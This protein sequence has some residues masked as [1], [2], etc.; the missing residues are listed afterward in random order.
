MKKRFL[1][2]LVAVTM[3]ISTTT[4][5]NIGI[6]PVTTTLTEIPLDEPINGGL[7]YHV[8]EFEVIVGVWFPFNDEGEINEEHI[9]DVRIYDSRTGEIIKELGELSFVEDEEYA[10]LFI[11][12]NGEIIQPFE[13]DNPMPEIPFELLDSMEKGLITM[14]MYGGSD[15]GNVYWW[16]NHYVSAVAWRIYAETLST[17]TVT[18][19][20]TP[21][22]TTATEP[23]P[24]RDLGDI[25]GNGHIQITDALE[26]LKFLA[27]LSSLLTT[28]PD[29]MTAARI[30]VETPANPT[31]HCVLEILKKLAGLPNLLS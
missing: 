18:P 20:T 9:A 10:Y 26:I 1:A 15:N 23:V 12:S 25:D 16:V 31:I 11:D 3:I 27:G 17:T 22:T 6:E 21:T 7:V 14:I 30:T 29:A 28:D 8:G 19:V 24:S 4:A 2:M 5:F 13:F